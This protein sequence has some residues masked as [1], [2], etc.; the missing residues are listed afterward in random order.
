LKETQATYIFRQKRYTKINNTQ[1]HLGI[2]KAVMVLSLIKITKMKIPLLLYKLLNEGI[3]W[4]LEQ[5]YKTK[6]PNS[7]LLM[8]WGNYI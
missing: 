4:Y 2:L 6:S 1:T 7:E 8:L 5:K 3:I